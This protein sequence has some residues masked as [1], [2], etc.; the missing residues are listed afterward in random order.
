MASESKAGDWEFELLPLPDTEGVEL[1]LLSDLSGTKPTEMYFEF[2]VLGL[3]LG[4]GK[5]KGRLA[6]LLND[7]K[8]LTFTHVRPFVEDLRP[9][10]N[11]LRVFLLDSSSQVIK[12]GD[13]YVEAEFFVETVSCPSERGFM[14]GQPALVLLQP[15]PQ[16]ESRA[17]ELMIDFFVTNCEL[18]K[19]AYGY[20]LRVY[21]DDDVITE[22]TDWAALHVTAAPALTGKHALRLV[23]VNPGGEELTIPKWNAKAHGITLL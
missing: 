14:F 5:G 20:K 10:Y 16:T 21:L 9:G 22:R 17:S 4:D 7:D 3:P 12:S 18:S 2:E 8:W 1:T 13:A 23:L 11:L 15:R 19:A 6:L